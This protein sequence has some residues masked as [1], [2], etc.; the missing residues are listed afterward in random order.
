MSVFPPSAD[1]LFGPVLSRLG[2]CLTVAVMVTLWLAVL[3][4]PL[5]V[6]ASQGEPSMGGMSAEA[7]GVLALLSANEPVLISATHSTHVLHQAPAIAT[8]IGT[9]QIR[10]MGARNLLDA[11]KLVPGFHIG[12]ADSFAVNTSLTVRG[13]QTVAS[14]QILLMID[15]HRVNEPH[16]GTWTILFDEFPLESVE[17]IEVIRGPG[18]ALYGSN[19][20]V[21]TINVIMKQPGKGNQAVVGGGN[22]NRAHQFLQL[23][24]KGEQGEVIAFY[25]HLDSNGT[26]DPIREVVLLDA[27]QN[28][29]GTESGTTNFWRNTHTGYAHGR[30]GKLSLTALYMNK[31]RG[32]TLGIFNRV[33]RGSE[34]FFRQG[35]AEAAYHGK[36]GVVDTV[37]KVSVDEF[38][39]DQA[40]RID[41]PL[42]PLP[43][44]SV[45]NNFLSA[46][47]VSTSIQ[48]MW[49]PAAGH[50]V[51]VGAAFDRVREYDVRYVLDGLDVSSII[52]L[53][54]PGSRNVTAVYAQD[55][56]AVAERLRLT[57]GL[58]LDHY[59]D[60]GNTLNPR[61][62]L[63]WLPSHELNFKLLYGHAFRAPS[64]LELNATNN[65]VV[66][67]N[68]NLS[69]ENIHT[70]EASANWLV[71][72]VLQTEISVFF[73]RVSDP[74]VRPPVLGAPW[75]NGASFD[76]WGVEAEV[77]T[78]WS[79]YRYGYLNGSWNQTRSR[80]VGEAAATVPRF[81]VKSGLNWPLL[82]RPNGRNL[83]NANLGVRYTGPQKRL[84]GDLRPK[85]KD[86]TVVDLALVHDRGGLSL[87]MKVHNLLD[88]A[89]HS[90]STPV[91]TDGFPLPGRTWL[92]EA[93]SRF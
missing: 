26:G 45:A 82:Q 7:D 73:N 85:S 36:V 62:A 86:S 43:F 18:S 10:D 89:V 69:P 29:I 5:P 88:K 52:P 19:A 16:V 25:D 75:Q 55:E 38:K 81:S 78:D 31:H 34:L 39:S 83:V 28:P 90:P 15:G 63:V 2:R 48:G 4:I 47:T 54:I 40:W 72:P 12:F 22:G 65:P 37:F 33:D 42:P 59:S 84:A 30:F 61:L 57:S 50:D 77:K 71:T 56:W 87:S 35:F 80:G 64:L 49:Q 20:F 93:R 6:W 46:R 66:V 32:S 91:V 53:S 1:P 3:A 68:P 21:A 44:V 70:V 67:G 14:D 13:L 17:R 41:V 79:E 11:L 92:L 8:V 23:D 74:V 27:L 58:R 76:S 24:H 9:K 51:I 60:F